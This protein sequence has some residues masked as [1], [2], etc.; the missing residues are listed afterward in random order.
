MSSSD[1][2]H[3]ATQVEQAFKYSPL[4]DDFAEIRLLEFRVIDDENE[5]IECAIITAPL[6][7]APPYEALSYAWGAPEPK[8]LIKLNSVAFGV[9]RNLYLALKHLLQT[10]LLLFRKLDLPTHRLWIDAICIDQSN[11]EERS[12]QVSLMSPIYK[13][14]MNVVIW[15][16]EPW[17]DYD[18][19]ADF[20]K[21]LH[22]NPALSP[23]IK[24]K[25]KSIDS[26]KVQDALKKF[27]S[28]PWWTRAWTVQEW[29]LA[30]RTVFH[31]GRYLLDGHIVR[32]SV[33]HYFHHQQACCVEHN[34][35][36]Q[37]N[38]FNILIVMEKL[39]YIR[40][41]LDNVSFPYVINHFRARRAT[42]MRDKIYGM[43]GLATGDY[44]NL[45]KPNYSHSTEQVFEASALAMIKRTRNLEVLSHIATF[46]QQNLKLPSFVPDWTAE[47]E[48]DRSYIDWLNWLSHLHLYNSCG[49]EAAD[50]KV[51]APGRIAL[52]GFIVDE[53]KS[54]GSALHSVPN[55]TF[56]DQM[57]NL[58]DI[59]CNPE[60][61]YCNSTITRKEA[62]WLAICGSIE[63]FF[64]PGRDNRPFYR[65]IPTPSNFAR[66]EKWALWFPTY[67]V[68]LFDPEVQSVQLPF[69]VMAKGRKFVVTTKGYV[70]FCP[71]QSEK[72]DVIAIFAGGSV[73]FVLRPDRPTGRCE[74][75]RGYTLVGDS[76]IHGIMD[77]ETFEAGREVSSYL[78]YIEL[79]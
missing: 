13:R 49:G 77:G 36:V 50:I 46:G 17:E 23:S 26:V 56:L 28:F 9:S 16:G 7:E 6:D 30:Q 76:Y 22:F 53:I 52:K 37:N 47:V 29:V 31:C 42:N 12:R 18:L 67:S 55:Q 75:G 72:G 61:I 41:L 48:H 60:E 57:H 19:A 54:T 43:L 78:E 27:F 58:A 4:N 45:A 39:E 40:L 11:L 69:R 25:G 34:N 1:Q 79:R 2:E 35:P 70:G 62:F 71:N 24:V 3:D 73:P 38:L 5:E 33:R 14:A 44:K 65:R 68:E 15:L 74:P 20:L 63:N 21:N 10:E 66:F 8:T 51:I 59:D 32:Q 64:D